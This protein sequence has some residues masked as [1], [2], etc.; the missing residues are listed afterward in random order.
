MTRFDWASAVKWVAILAIIVIILKNVKAI[1]APVSQSEIVGD[2]VLRVEGIVNSLISQGKV[3]KV[4]FQKACYTAEQ[5]ILFNDKQ[6]RATKDS[7][8]KEA[9][10]AKWSVNNQYPGL[11]G[12]GG[13]W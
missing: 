7:E 6:G 12:A 8:I 9:V 2:Q 10:L 4:N 13:S 5:L 1:F 3:A 11:S